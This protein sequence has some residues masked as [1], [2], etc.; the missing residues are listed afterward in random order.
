MEKNNSLIKKRKECSMCKCYTKRF[1][2]IVLALINISCG[3]EEDCSNNENCQ[4]GQSYIRSLGKCVAVED[5]SPCAISTDCDDDEKCIVVAEGSEIPGKCVSV[6][7]FADSYGHHS[8][9]FVGQDR[10]PEIVDG[11]WHDST[12]NLIWQNPPDPEMM[13][14]YKA[15]RYCNS[16]TLGGFND[17]SLPTI[18][19][20]RSLIRNWPETMT[21]GTCGVSDI[22][23]DWECMGCSECGNYTGTRYPIDCYWPDEMEGECRFYWSAVPYKDGEIYTEADFQIKS[24]KMKTSPMIT[25]LT[26][27]VDFLFA[28]L[29]YETAM[30]EKYVRCV[31]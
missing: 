6:L 20:L 12:S 16:L 30:L 1:L 21:G 4:F 13:H 2:I 10:S 25:D 11:V 17:W 27:S 31:R 29:T 3:G 28:K 19:E 18:S 22:C 15:K 24:N 7:Y 23:F 14:Y 9:G 5:C 26:W 8:A